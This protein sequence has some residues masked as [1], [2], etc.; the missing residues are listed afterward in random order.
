MPDRVVEALALRPGDVACDVGAGSGYLALR[1]ARAVG[2]GATST[3][4]T[5]TRG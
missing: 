1:M 5:W 3:P 4:S 2:P